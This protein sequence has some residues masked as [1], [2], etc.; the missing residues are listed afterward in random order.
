MNRRNEKSIKVY[1]CKLD[2]I[3]FQVSSDSKTAVVISDAS[4]KNQV[5]TSIAH[6]YTHN[7]PVIKIIHYTINVTLTEAKLF[8]IRCSINQAIYLSNINQIIIIMDSIHT[9]KRIFD[10]FNYLYQI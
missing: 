7:S 4:I 3:T 10:L 1:I 2:K 5:T 8:I 6:I 9:A